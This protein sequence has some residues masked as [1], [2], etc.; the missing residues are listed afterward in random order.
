MRTVNCYLITKWSY[1]SGMVYFLFWTVPRYLEPPK[2][3]APQHWGETRLFTCLAS[4]GHG[5]PQGRLAWGR[6]W[7][8]RRGGRR[9]ERPA[10]SGSWRRPTALAG[11]APVTKTMVLSCYAVCGYK[12]LL[13]KIS[14]SLLFTS[15]ILYPPRFENH[16]LTNYRYRYRYVEMKPF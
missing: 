10:C 6:R 11:Q 16:L 15:K 4:G 7:W 1:S 5:Q 2:K 14:R 13:Q 8:G 12:R 3:E 9:R